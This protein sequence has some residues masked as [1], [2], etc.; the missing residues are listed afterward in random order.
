LEHLKRELKVANKDARKTQSLNIELQ[1]DVV[2]LQ[3]EL[4]KKQYQAQANLRSIIDKFRVKRK[5]EIELATATTLQAWSEQAVEL[6]VLRAD[7]VNQELRGPELW[8]LDQAN[9]EAVH[10]NLTTD[11]WRIALTHREEIA[12]LLVRQ[13]EQVR[14]MNVEMEAVAEPVVP[15]A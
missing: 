10:K 12:K 14:M 15:A 5:A 8:K 7:K 9:Y 4:G 11:F 2:R 1:K 13:K 6:Q 3:E